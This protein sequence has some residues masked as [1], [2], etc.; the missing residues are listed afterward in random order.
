MIFAGLSRIL[1]K[2]PGVTPITSIRPELF[3]RAGGGNLVCCGR[4]SFAFGGVL[5]LPGDRAFGVV[6]HRVP[7]SA[8]LFAALP[9]LSCGCTACMIIQS[10]ANAS[11]LWG[12]RV[13]RHA[14]GVLTQFKCLAVDRRRL[15]RRPQRAYFAKMMKQLLLCTLLHL[16]WTFLPR[17]NQS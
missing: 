16:L 15:P 7:F 10:S 12:S 9:P 1:C 3:R 17:G 4:Q 11:R 6:V 2:M 8:L 5:S 13:I 14:K